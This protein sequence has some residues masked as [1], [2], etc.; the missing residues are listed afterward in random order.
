[1]CG[2]IVRGNRVVVTAP[3]DLALFHDYGPDWDFTRCSGL[4][5]KIQSRAHEMLL[6]YC[7]SGG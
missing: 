2:W 4:L 1:V 7:A 5:R 3:Y 6:I